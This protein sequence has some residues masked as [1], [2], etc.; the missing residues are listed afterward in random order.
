MAP[1]NSSNKISVTSRRWTRSAG[2]RSTVHASPALATLC[3]FCL[4]E[5]LTQPPSMAMVVG[6]CTWRHPKVIQTVASC[7]SRYTGMTPQI[8]AMSKEPGL[9]QKLGEILGTIDQKLLVAW[10]NPTEISRLNAAV[11]TEDERAVLQEK[12]IADLDE[13]KDCC[14]IADC[15]PR[16]VVATYEWSPE[17]IFSDEEDDGLESTTE[18]VRFWEV[19]MQNLPD[20]EDRLWIQSWDKP[21]LQ[22]CSDFTLDCDDLK[23][24]FTLVFHFME[25]PYFTNNTLEKSYYNFKSSPNTVESDA[26]EIKS[27]EIIWKPGKD[28]TVERIIKF[29]EEEEKQPRFSFF[30]NF[31]C[32]LKQGG[33]FP[34]QFDEDSVRKMT[35]MDDRE[36]MMEMLMGTEYELGCSMR[37][38][39]VRFAPS[40]RKGQTSIEAGHCVRAQEAGYT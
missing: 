28:V 36:K 21:V 9:A 1:A 40:T 14:G 27:T 31:F 35:G 12:F 22:Y 24:G 7:W 19:A 11:E 13:P 18:S 33:A 6:L 4:S 37:N 10:S 26:M 30:R 5:E 29:N 20:L 38:Q 8:Y 17:K 32:N 34:D 3:P 39:L 2:D 25:N 16:R 15:K 23:K